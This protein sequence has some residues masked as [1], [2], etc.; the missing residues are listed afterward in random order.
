MTYEKS[1][2]LQEQIHKGK[3][4]YIG[5]YSVVKYTENNHV[6]WYVNNSRI[7]CTCELDPSSATERLRLLPVA[8]Y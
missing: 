1:R 2:I 5:M 6:L 3:Y 7:V 8:D 4:T